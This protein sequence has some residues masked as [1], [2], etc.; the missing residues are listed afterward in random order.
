MKFALRPTVLPVVLMLLF[1]SCRKDKD[2]SSVPEANPILLVEFVG[3]Y[4]TF[5][6]IDS[7]Q[8]SWESGNQKSQIHFIKRN[9]SLFLPLNQLPAQIQEFEIQLFAA[10]RYNNQ[11]QGIWKS[12]AQ[13]NTGSGVSVKLAA[14]ESF[15][16]LDW[17]PRVRLKDAIGHEASLA[18]R[19]DDAYFKIAPTPHNYPQIVFERAYWNTIGGVQPI[20]NK[21]WYCQND[22][23]D[24]PNDSFFADMPERVG[25]KNWNHISLTILFQ[26]DLVVGG[27][28][29]LTLEWEP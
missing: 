5:S 16:D 28:W 23:I 9:D 24:Q 29:L 7:A 2:D 1:V 6:E 20:A 26:E 21:T 4:L 8:I 13:I 18:L 3:S 15:A 17:K 10:K 11:Y 25:Q 27:G 14:P 22:C 12:A 19:P